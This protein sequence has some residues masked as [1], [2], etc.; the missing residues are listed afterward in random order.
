MDMG[1]PFSV[2][3]MAGMPNVY[4]CRSQSGG[5]GGGDHR[6]DAL[7]RG[8]LRPIIPRRPRRWETENALEMGPSV[9]AS[10]VANESCAVPLGTV[11]KGWA[12]GH[13]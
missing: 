9:R 12:Q 4:G 1:R 10:G 7:R 8:A 13:R 11:T 3:R 2:G 6:S 5:G